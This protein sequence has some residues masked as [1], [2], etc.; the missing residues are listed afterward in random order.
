[1]FKSQFPDCLHVGNKCDLEPE[2]QVRFQ[3]AC[4][5]AKEGGVLAALET[6]AKVTRV[7]THIK[8]RGEV[9]KLVKIVI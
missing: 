9:L 8:H 6:S 3:E 1:M 7:L 4:N 2:R 5:L